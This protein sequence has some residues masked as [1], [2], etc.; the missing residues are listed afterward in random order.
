MNK[1]HLLDEKTVNK[2]AA[3]EVVERPASIVKELVEN[4]I[5]AGSKNI[6]VEILEG[7]IPYIKV[8]DDGCG[9]NEI[10]AVLAFER[11]ATS[12][13]RS[14]EDLFNITTLGFRG[15][16]LASI[17]AVSKVVLQTKEENE[18][19][20]TR[21]VV[22]GGKI[23]EKTRCGC[24]KGTSVEVKDVFF[25]T[26]AR[27]KFLKRP[28]TEAMYVT[29]VVTR[30]CL[31]NPGI[32]FKYVKD[33][34]VQFI[35]SGNGSIEDVILRLFGKEVHSALIFSEFEAEDLKVK[36]F[37]TKNFLNYSN[38]N[39]QFFY[40][41]GRYVKNKTLSAAV[42]EAFKTYVPSDRY[43]GVFLYLEINPRFIDV[44][45]HPSKLEVKFSDDRRIFESVYRTIREALRES[46]LIPEV[47]LE[48]D[49]KNEEG[50]IGEQVKLSLPLFEVKE[51]T[52][53]GAIFVREE[54]KTEE[55]IDKAPKHESSSDSERNVKRLSD[56]RIVGTLFST[57]VIVEKGDVFYIIDQH[58][59]HERILYEKLVSQYE[60]V[61]SRQVTFPIVVELQPGDM[62][63]VGQERELLYKLGYVFEEFGNNS[64][65]LREVPV[66]L[67]QPE[68]KKLF[69]EIVERLRDKDFSSKVSFKEEE[70][71][72]MACKAA[73]K[74][75]D[76]L[77]E[78][79]IYKLFE[80]LKIAENPY[81]CPHGRPVIISMTKT[82]LEKMF[83]RIK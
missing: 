67:G 20:G 35:T 46:N 79:E 61:Q 18:T 52:D 26:P 69:V 80:D 2:I 25:N 39:M 53:D 55:K 41:N 40:V 23:L 28:S 42:D 66:I 72:T 57:Y 15:E 76:T 27:R 3:G 38:R 29:E 5:D 71:A 58:A 47:K 37:A 33:K 32:S 9:M 63:I 82:Q 13:I 30:L 43:P 6:T 7:G 59:A 77:S 1:I 16:A 64:V 19:F 49:L 48:K 17:A 62:E 83:K 36:A 12:K 11:H 81:T 51:K 8:T 45:I 54:V 56:I 60:R 65:V 31:S 78:N 4:S 24:Q 50:Q 44:N 68:A 75:M 10:D 73:V 70:I 22:E 14:D 21:L 74:A 34:K